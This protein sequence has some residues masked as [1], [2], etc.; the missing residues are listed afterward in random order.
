MHRAWSCENG[1]NDP[2]HDSADEKGEGHHPEI[3]QVFADLFRKC[4]RW[5]CCY[6]KRYQGKTER[7]CQ[8]GAIA[9]RASRER[10]NK[11]QDAAP[12][13]NRQRQNGAELDNDRV[14]F[15]KAIVKIDMQQ[16]FADTQMRS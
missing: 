11:L 12:K 7:I 14:H 1:V 3:F 4:P 9:A 10:A 8:N 5:N 6:N 2:H 13:I 16:G 15:P